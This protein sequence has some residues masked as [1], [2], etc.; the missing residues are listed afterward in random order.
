M[1]YF[2]K[3]HVMRKILLVF[4]LIC[5][6]WGVCSCG[7][8]HSWSTQSY[9]VDSAKSMFN[10]NKTD[11]DNVAQIV[12]SSDDFWKNENGHNGYA[13][14]IFCDDT[15][16]MYKKDFT[17]QEWDVINNFTKNTQPLSITRYVDGVICISY[18]DADNRNDHIDFYYNV[19][20]P[21][22]YGQMRI[23]FGQIDENWYMA[24]GTSI[25]SFPSFN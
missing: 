5:L 18:G 25:P 19:N 24:Y 10:T 4:M 22:Y 17:S 3:S 20:D 23:Y 2:Q 7:I 11:F 8:S 14:E 1:S 16:G 15:I 21:N 9:T 12:L 13:A 6:F